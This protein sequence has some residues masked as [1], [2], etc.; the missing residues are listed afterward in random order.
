MKSSCKPDVLVCPVWEWHARR[1]A[2]AVCATVRRVLTF[3]VACLQAEEERIAVE[4]TAADAETA[5]APPAA[6]EAL[7][8]DFAAKIQEP[9]SLQLEAIAEDIPSDA[10]GEKNSSLAGGVETNSGAEAEA[11]LED[12]ATT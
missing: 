9:N 8:A 7:S 10:S 5:A 11:E 1:L 6:S 2:G 12:R 3:P 4:R